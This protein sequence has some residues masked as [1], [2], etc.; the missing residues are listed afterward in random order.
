VEVK[1]DALVKRLRGDARSVP[2]AEIVKLITALNGYRGVIHSLQ[3]DPNYVQTLIA[4]KSIQELNELVDQLPSTGLHGKSRSIGFNDFVKHLVPLLNDIESGVLTI[5]SMFAEMI[6]EGQ[7]AIGVAFNN[8]T[9]Q[10]ATAEMDMK[11]LR[12]AVEGVR[13]MKSDTVLVQQTQQQMAQQ[14]QENFQQQVLLQAERLMQERL[15]ARNRDED[16]HDA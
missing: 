4:G 9:R 16:M 2:D 1:V 10:G 11:S 12:A 15:N 6:G 14:I 3:N 13:K 5:K 8:S 7:A